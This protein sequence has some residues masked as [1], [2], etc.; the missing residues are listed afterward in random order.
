MGKSPNRQLEFVLES[1][2]LLLVFFVIVALCGVFFSLGYIV[3]R[4]TLS[5]SI[6]TAQATTEASAAADK[7]SP[8]PPASYLN[9]PEAGTAASPDS[10]APGTDLSFYQSAEKPAE[11]APAP[12][13]SSE[14]PTGQPASPPPEVQS[15]LPAPPPGILVQVSA[16]TRREDAETLVQFLKEKKLPVMVTAGANDALFHV[17]V[18]PYQDEKE[19]QRVRALL[20]Q[21]GF[22]PILKR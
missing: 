7:P 12:L 2:Q 4:N 10:S 19:A 8:M 20:E 15:T 3:G 9:R 16:L 18:G 5:E 11:S 14:T 13:E 22:R 17:V 6:P 21:D 1:R